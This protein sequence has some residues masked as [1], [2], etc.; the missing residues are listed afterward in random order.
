MLA[1][2]IMEDV[3]TFLLKVSNSHKMSH[4]FSNNIVNTDNISK[5]ELRL[6]SIEPHKSFCE[7]KII[8]Q[9]VIED[10]SLR[11]ASQFLTPMTVSLVLE[12]HPVFVVSSKKKIYCV[13]GLR[14]LSI[15]RQCMPPSATIPVHLISSISSEEEEL[16]CMADLFIIST[17]FNMSSNESVYRRYMLITELIRD[18][19]SFI[20][21]KQSDIAR[22]LNV[23]PA[24]IN[25]WS[26]KIS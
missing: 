9:L 24:S 15:A 26:K 2:N 10:F 13:S 3:K 11:N 7:L 8:E 21:N 16:L 1:N 6:E 18:K 20:G 4:F 17:C 5:I 19:L 14:S 22:M 23:T 25:Q 12:L